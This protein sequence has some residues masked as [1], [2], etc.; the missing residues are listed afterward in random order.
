M[1]FKDIR[2]KNDAVV[3][4]LDH[5]HKKVEIMVKVPFPSSEIQAHT[6]EIDGRITAVLEYVRKEGFFLNINMKE[7][8]DYSVKVHFF[9]CLKFR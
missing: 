7:I 2:L 1:N 6:T 5:Q 4:L 9:H 8:G 3:Q